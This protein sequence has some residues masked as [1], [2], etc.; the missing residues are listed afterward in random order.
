MNIQEL[1]NE[2]EIMWEEV[3]LPYTAVTTQHL[4]VGTTNQSG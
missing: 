1:I 3:F 4:R 2:L